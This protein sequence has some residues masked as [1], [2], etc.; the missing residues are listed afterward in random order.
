VY[1]L[2]SNLKNKT[3]WSVCVIGVM[4]VLW[5]AHAPAPTGRTPGTTHTHNQCNYTVSSLSMCINDA[6]EALLYEESRLGIP[7]HSIYIHGM[8]IPSVIYVFPS[9]CVLSSSFPCAHPFSLWLLCCVM[10][11]CMCDQSDPKLAHVH[12]R[13]LVNRVQTMETVGGA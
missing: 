1:P 8:C 2:C 13:A 11:I 10:A 7:S 5:A 9:L 12:L 6:L 4:Q 3:N